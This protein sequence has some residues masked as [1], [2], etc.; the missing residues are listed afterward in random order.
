M[1]YLTNG[2]KILEAYPRNAELIKKRIGEA[3]WND[4]TTQTAPDIVANYFDWRES[5]ERLAFWAELY[6]NGRD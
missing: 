1:T 4:V 2:Q 5:P 6:E 3:A